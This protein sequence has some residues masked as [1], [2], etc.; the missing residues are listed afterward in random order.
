MSDPESDSEVQFNIRPNQNTE[1]HQVNDGQVQQPN[2]NSTE[3][4][5]ES[6]D[7]QNFIQD[8]EQGSVSPIQS[9]ESHEGQVHCLSGS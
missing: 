8:N 1:D 2:D 6:I 7:E 4:E 9:N 5:N 3:S